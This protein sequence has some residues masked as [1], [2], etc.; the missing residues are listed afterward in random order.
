MAGSPTI[1]ELTKLSSR[2]SWRP[3]AP[4]ALPRRSSQELERNHPETATAI[5][6]FKS[7]FSAQSY[8]HAAEGSDLA[9]SAVVEAPAK[10]Q[11]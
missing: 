10:E 4:R 9:R 2:N 6:R 3:K 8:L 7:S 11:A 5:A 1:A